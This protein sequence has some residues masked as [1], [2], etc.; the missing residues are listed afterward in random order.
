MQVF[1]FGNVERVLFRLVPRSGMATV[2]HPRPPRGKI[3]VIPRVG[4]VGSGRPRIFFTANTTGSSRE[5]ATI[6]LF[7]AVVGVSQGIG[8]TGVSFQTILAV[9][10]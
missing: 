10:R 2:F 4:P 1:R 3:G 5:L 6:A 8:S 9:W 7:S